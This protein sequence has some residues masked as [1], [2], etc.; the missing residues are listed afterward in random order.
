M[1]FCKNSVASAATSQSYN[2]T[3]NANNNYNSLSLKQQVMINQFMSITGCC[4]EQ[5]IEF[6]RST[7]WQ[8]QVKIFLNL[9]LTHGEEHH[10]AD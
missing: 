1:S 10:E 3:T 8:Y 9:T 4:C 2:N 6:L 7:N 5:S